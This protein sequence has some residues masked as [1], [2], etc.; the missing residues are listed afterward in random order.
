MDFE[1]SE[2]DL[3]FLSREELL[4]IRKE[5]LKREIESAKRILESGIEP[6]K[7]ADQ[8]I[9]DTFKL[10]EEG[11]KRRNP[12]V[13]SEGV[14]KKVKDNLALIDKIKSYKKI[15]EFNFNIR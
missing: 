15:S 9:H 8:F 6:L 13:N 12:D 7:I 11:I 10:I 2:S 1:Y 5:K 3:K 14:K 4:F